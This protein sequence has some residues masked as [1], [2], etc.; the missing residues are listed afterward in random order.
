M[1]NVGRRFD[2][3]LLDVQHFIHMIDHEP[4]LET[5][6]IHND[7]AL[8]LMDT[9]LDLL[10]ESVQRCDN[11]L[12]GSGDILAERLQALFVQAIIGDGAGQLADV[13]IHAPGLGKR[14]VEGLARTVEPGKPRAHL[15][16]R[17]DHLMHFFLATTS[18]ALPQ[19][20]LIRFDRDATGCG[21]LRRE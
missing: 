21:V 6:G 5:V 8:V 3:F 10:L 4:Q 14:L 16:R 7:D 20:R 2:R 15:F 17:L 9:P 19:P 13:L 1:S 11:C 18:A 12:G